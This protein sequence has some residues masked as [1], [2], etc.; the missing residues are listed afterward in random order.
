M[1]FT[2]AR[3]P[4]R[5]ES[6][7]FDMDGLRYL[8]DF[9]LPDGKCWF[10]VKPFDPNEREIEKARRLARGTGKMVFLAPGNPVREIG[11]HVFSPTGL[12]QKDWRFA[13][14]H[15]DG[16]GY[17]AC[18]VWRAD[19]RVRIRNTDAHVGCY[20]MGPEDELDAAGNHQFD[21]KGRAHDNEPCRI[22][23]N[24]WLRRERLP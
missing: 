1:F 14:A 12:S 13:Y 16:I 2:E 4:F 20:G 15:E 10:E 22:I 5:Y 24:P 23:T 6:E 18:D 3:I 19:L 9:W 21:G 17:I 11:L 8:P 7:G